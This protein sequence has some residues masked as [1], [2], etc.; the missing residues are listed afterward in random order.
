MNINPLTNEPK[1][2]QSLPVLPSPLERLFDGPM[3]QEMLLEPAKFGLGLVPQKSQPDA[4]TNMVCGFCSTGCA[5]N[6]HMKDG[7]AINLSPTTDYPV[8]IGMACPKGWEALAP[9]ASPCIC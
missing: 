6:V 4:T 7:E 3:T 5:L 9:L 8:N 2:R 1:K